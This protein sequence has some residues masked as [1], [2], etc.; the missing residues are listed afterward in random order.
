MMPASLSKITHTPD[1]GK[2]IKIFA[3]AVIVVHLNL[4]GHF[5]FIFLCAYRRLLAEAAIEKLELE[6]AEKAFVHS[7]DYQGIQFVKRL[8]KLDVCEPLISDCLINCFFF[9]CYF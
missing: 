4:S 5:Q 6:V 2:V 1:Y 7:R 3:S 8:K 9:P